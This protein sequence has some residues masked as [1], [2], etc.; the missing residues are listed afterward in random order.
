MMLKFIKRPTA[1]HLL[2]G[3]LQIPV[4]VTVTWNKPEKL[5][6]LVEKVQ[7]VEY[8]LIREYVDDS[9]TILQELRIEGDEE[10]GED[11]DDSDCEVDDEDAEI[12]AGTV[13]NEDI[14]I[15]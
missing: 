6:I 9:K 1:S 7:G 15:S 4:K 13:V 5:S 12:Q 3:G 2:Q 14:G 8:T 10:D 11:D